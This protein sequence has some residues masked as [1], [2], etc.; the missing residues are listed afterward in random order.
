M[1]TLLKSFGVA[2][3]V[4]PDTGVR[5]AGQVHETDWSFPLSCICHQSF[6]TAVRKSQAIHVTPGKTAP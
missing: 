3:H 1:S 5:S 2:A 4:G 6:P